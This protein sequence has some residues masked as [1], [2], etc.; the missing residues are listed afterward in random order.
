MPS[1]VIT[2]I[3]ALAKAGAVIDLDGQHRLVVDTRRPIDQHTAYLVRRHRL[4]LAWAVA[5][6]RSGHEYL[7]C[8]TCAEPQLLEPDKAGRL[9]HMTPG[10]KG[11]IQRPASRLIDPKGAAWRNQVRRTG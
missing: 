5:G 9:C 3:G 4:A 8:G 2:A 10:C 1:T 6:R 7:V 11:K